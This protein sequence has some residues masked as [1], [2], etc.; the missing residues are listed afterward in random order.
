[1]AKEIA[2]KKKPAKARLTPELRLKEFVDTY[3]Q[4]FNAARAYGLVFGLKNEASARSCAS[5]YL[6]ESNVQQYL[7][8]VLK[9]RREA[10]HLDTTYVVRKLNDIVEA[11]YTQ[12]I[13]VMTEEQ[14]RA[15][16][17]GIRKLVQGVKLKKKT[18]LSGENNDEEI[19]EE[20]EVTFMSKDKALEALGRHTGA[21]MKDNLR[22]NVDMGKMSYTDMILAMSELP[23]DAE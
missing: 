10:L 18:W 6:T 8:Q 22:G 7:R 14:L 13:R 11:D 23:D 20:Y 5:K 3:V 19:T 4:D 12:S 17:E 21:F 1:M 15:M 16:P 9:E 2:K